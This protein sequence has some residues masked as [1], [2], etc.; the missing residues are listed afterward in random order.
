MDVAYKNCSDMDSEPDR[1]YQTGNICPCTD[2]N[3]NYCVITAYH[4]VCNVIFL[5]L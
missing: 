2:R 4:T 5:F 3:C 1:M